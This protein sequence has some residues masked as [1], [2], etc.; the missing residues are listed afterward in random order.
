MGGGKGGLGHGLVGKTGTFRWPTPFPVAIS[1]VYLAQDGVSASAM[2]LVLSPR[3]SQDPPSPPLC[4]GKG[5]GVRGPRRRPTGPHRGAFLD[6]GHPCRGE[7]GRH[8]WTASDVAV[9]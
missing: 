3:S 4:G 6:N 5:P 9:P 1:R 8:L 2:A 7:G